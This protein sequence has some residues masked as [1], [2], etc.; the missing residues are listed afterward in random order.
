[1]STTPSA[2]RAAPAPLRAPASPAPASLPEALALLVAAIRVRHYS[3]RTE[4]AYTGHL[5]RFRRWLATPAGLVHRAADSTA[6][7]RA[8]LTHLATVD[9]VA[10]KTQN[11]SFNA[12]VFFYTHALQRPL[13]D[14]TQIPRAKESRRLPTI[15]SPAQVAAI[16][17]R[18]C[19]TPAAPVRL[20]NQ[21]LYG[22]GLRVTECLE[23]RLRSI[24]LA[25]STLTVTAGKGGQDRR[26]PIPCALIPALRAQIARARA[27]HAADCARSPAPLPVALPEPVARKYPRYAY[28]PAFAWLFPAPAPCVHPR[29]GQLVRWRLHEESLRRA[30]RAAAEPLGLAGHVTPHVF[31]H[32]YATQLLGLGADIRTVQEHLGHKDVE[33]TMIY[34]HTAPAQSRARSL[35]DALPALTPLVAA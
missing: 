34:T 8:Y 23:L 11:Q 19:D 6:K 3:Y 29:T 27:L 20:I 14:L 31:R 28:A 5:V 9:R 22:C 32:A 16:L 7:V 26:V 1:M 33:T 21:L 17:A 24:N 13:G 35:V 25:T 4:Q 30:M 18:L 2:L 15:L 10:A 12:L